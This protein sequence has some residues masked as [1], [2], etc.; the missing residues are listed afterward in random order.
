MAA[1]SAALT[2]ALAIGDRLV[3]QRQAVAHRAFGG[4]RD[5]AQRLVLDRDLLGPGDLGEDA[6]ISSV[7]IHAPQVETLAARQ[8][9]DR[10]FA[11]LGRGEDELHMRRRLFQR[12]QQRIEGVLR[13]HVHFVDDVDLVA[14]LDRRIAH[15][16][17]DLAHVV[18]A[19]IGGGVHLDHVDM[20]RFENGRAVGRHFRHV[21]RGPARIVEGAG[22]EP[23]GRRLADA[24]HA[25][26]HIGLGDAPGRE[27]IG[28][29]AHH[30]FLADQVGE[31]LRAVFAGEDAITGGRSR[32]LSSSVT[33]PSLPV[34]CALRRR[35]AGRATR[36]NLVRAAS[37]RT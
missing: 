12:L 8:D 9:G 21:D 23:R 15:A 31:G 29:G 24:A 32:R 33:G 6:R 5:H 36:A 11:D 19:G 16:L 7:R 4:A 3:E 35:E 18:D 1:T 25:G 14:R 22:D 27:G 17:D 28:Q 2:S 26:Q 37:F 34:Q 30:R 20:A 13:Q 10:N